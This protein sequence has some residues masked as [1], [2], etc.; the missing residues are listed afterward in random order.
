MCTCMCM[1]Q[2]NLFNGLNLN[3]P[4][5]WD[6]TDLA[7]SVRTDAIR[8]WTVSLKH[9]PNERN[10]S[11]IMGWLAFLNA[12]T[13]NEMMRNDFMRKTSWHHGIS[14]ESCVEKHSFWP[15]TMSISM[16]VRARRVRVSDKL[17][18]TS[19]PNTSKAHRIRPNV[20]W[21]IR[22]MHGTMHLAMHMPW[23]HVPKLMIRENK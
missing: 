14:W 5:R 12:T 19:L 17:N 7:V 2:W 13:W 15:L 10:G 11:R 8:P 9:R 18:L 21:S 22:H 3:T 23:W 6:E 20:S 16:S 4:I 1:L